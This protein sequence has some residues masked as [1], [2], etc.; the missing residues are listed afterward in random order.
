MFPQKS[1]IDT[2]NFK[3][4]Y[5]NILGIHVSFQGCMDFR[6]LD[7]E[8]FNF[9]EVPTFRRCCGSCGS[10][11]RCADLVEFV[12]RITFAARASEFELCQ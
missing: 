8:F 5:R 10:T 9:W 1:N 12:S 6:T 11:S 2:L 4:S 7:L 3:G